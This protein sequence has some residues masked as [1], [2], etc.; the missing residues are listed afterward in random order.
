VA[1]GPDQ[2]HQA[3]E[4]LAAWVADA[5]VRGHSGVVLLCGRPVGDG[6][7]RVD[8]HDLHG[9]AAAD[10]RRVGAHEAVKG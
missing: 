4:V 7:F 6:Q 10:V 9:P 2:R 5:Q 8:V 3:F 1:V